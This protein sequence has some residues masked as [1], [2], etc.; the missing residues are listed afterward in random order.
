MSTANT[1]AI[2]IVAN[3]AAPCLTCEEPIEPGEEASWVRGVGVWHLDCPPPKNLA[4]YVRDAAA[5]ARKVGR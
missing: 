2:R 4:T 1:K 3:H 5:A